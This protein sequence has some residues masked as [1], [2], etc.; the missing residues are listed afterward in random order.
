MKNHLVITTVIN[1]NKHGQSIN[2]L[3]SGDMEYGH[4]ELL[5][6]MDTCIRFE[7]P[8]VVTMRSPRSNSIPTAQQNSA[9][10]DID[11]T[12]KSFTLHNITGDGNCLLKE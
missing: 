11:K 1:K 10:Q 5:T 9:N 6:P 4:F 7:A 8:Q 12:I 2:L 3:L